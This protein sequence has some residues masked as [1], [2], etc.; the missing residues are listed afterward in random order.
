MYE[1]VMSLGAF[2]KQEFPGISDKDVSEYIKDSIEN[3]ELTRIHE[4]KDK[5]LNGSLYTDKIV[6][7]K[8]FAGNCYNINIY[9]PEHIDF[10]DDLKAM[11][12]LDGS[13]FLSKNITEFSFP[14]LPMIENLIESEKIPPLACI[15]L[16]PYSKGPGYPIYGGSDNRSREYD[17]CSGDYSSFLKTEIIPE[18][19]KKY[20]I[21]FNGSL[22]M[23]ASSGGAAAFGAAW[24]NPDIF[25]KAFIS[26]SSFV[27][28]RGADKYIDMVRKEEKKPIKIYMQDGSNDLN[29]ILGDWNLSNKMMA[30][31]LAYR[32]YDFIFNNGSGGHNYFHLAEIFEEAMIWLMKD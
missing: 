9:I 15:F 16:D 22:I 32:G 10:R 29:T 4:L 1:V 30:S 7:S 19:Q 23:G 3:Y 17:T 21:D 31:S 12:I 25:S 13:S 18:L 27:N 6:S 28:I 20:P 14:I 24:H 26:I 2:L 11:F 8:V 5:K